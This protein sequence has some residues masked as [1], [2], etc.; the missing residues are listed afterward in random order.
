MM[1]HSYQNGQAS[2]K[3]I[4][5]LCAHLE[6]QMT[7]LVFLKFQKVGHPSRKLTTV[8]PRG[9]KT[10]P[11]STEH[12][13]HF[14][15]EEKQRSQNKGRTDQFWRWLE[16]AAVLQAIGV[17]W[18]GRGRTNA[19]LRTSTTFLAAPPCSVFMLSR[20]PKDATDFQC[21]LIQMT[22]SSISSAPAKTSQHL[23]NSNA[24]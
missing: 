3:G 6:S 15:Q 1:F 16:A 10:G 17:C 22:Q 5:L 14:W 12:F 2:R 21:S 18:V 24:C 4:P 20:H 19:A 23:E 11:A 13:R 9:K 7:A 8:L